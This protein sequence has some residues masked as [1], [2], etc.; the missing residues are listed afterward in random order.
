[1]GPSCSAD[2]IGARPTTGN[3]IAPSVPTIQ[4]SEYALC[5]LESNLPTNT[6]TAA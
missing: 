4:K 2:L 3:W 1:M 5:A 6:M